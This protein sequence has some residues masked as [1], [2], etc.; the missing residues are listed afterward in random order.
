MLI[1]RIF[2]VFI[3]LGFHV[4]LASNPLDLLKQDKVTPEGTAPN[5]FS[6]LGEWWSYV[7]ISHDNL[8]E[9]IAH[10]KNVTNDSV[11]SVRPEL[12][13]ELTSTLQQINSYLDSIA[14]L[15]VTA[16]KE[17]V[18]V[19]EEKSQY[20]IEEIQSLFTSYHELS[21]TRDRLISIQNEEESRAKNAEKIVADTIIA[22]RDIKENTENKLR[23]GLIIMANRLNWFVWKI[24]APIQQSKLDLIT[25]RLDFILAELESISETLLVEKSTIRKLNR[26]IELQSNQLENIH[27]QTLKAKEAYTEK[28]GVDFVSRLEEKLY[29]QKVLNSEITEKQAELEL[30]MLRSL[31]A[32]A[33]LNKQKESIEELDPIQLLEE[34]IAIKNKASPA[35]QN[36]RSNI[37]AERDAIQELLS[38]GDLEE[39]E[40]RIKRILDQRI[41][42][43]KSTV[44]EI[45]RLEQSLFNLDT[46]QKVLEKKLG[47]TQ[48][49]LFK[50]RSSGLFL[51]D[52]TFVRIWDLLNSKL[53]ELGNVPVTSWDI[54]QAIIILFATY[55]IARIL[56]RTLIRL[57]KT[58]EGKIPPAMYTLSRVIFYTF[59]VLGGFAAFAS[60]GVN[61]TNL[62]IV[63]GALSVGIGF[64]LQS[65]VNNFVSGIIIL[66]EHNIKVGDFIELDTGLRGTVRDIN[67]RCTIVNTLDNLD[68]IVPNSELVSAKVTNYTLNEPIVRI[69]V[70]FGVAYGSDKELVRKAVLE[71]AKNVEITY[72]DGANRRT[73]VWLVGFGDSSLDFELVVWLNP[74][75]GRAAPGSWRALYSWEIESALKRHNI[76]IPFPQRDLH[77][78]S[79]FNLTD[80]ESGY[81]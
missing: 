23:L 55:F 22:Y 7:D 58:P 18:V 59:I 50:L 3:I 38:G 78:K 45:T 60:I 15:K 70:P 44:Q 40:Q 36:W 73:Q 13:K 63:A 79:G 17:E 20:T 37:V 11:A 33:V 81:K 71:A 54:I 8:D 39:D 68:I 56:Q 14:E 6:L 48:G 29:A 26:Q 65:I 46:L 66:F 19:L 10:V 43:M 31:L 62:A 61:F 25:T 34:N 72:D 42:A 9:R 80:L 32:L 5:P 53:F 47:K 67:V 69:H 41:S 51:F 74:K 12:Q 21:T 64:G 76:E 2:F 35:I 75:L 1:I 24:D 30:A 27:K 57:N 49:W 4:G 52:Q 28:I 77:I 16:S